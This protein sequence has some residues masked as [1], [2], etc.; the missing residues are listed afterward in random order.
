MLIM[1]II[2]DRHSNF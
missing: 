1:N 2:D